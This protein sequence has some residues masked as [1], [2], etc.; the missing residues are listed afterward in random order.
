MQSSEVEIQVGTDRYMQIHTNNSDTYR[1]MQNKVYSVGMYLS[2]GY[3]QIITDTEMTL[4]QLYMMHC[5]L[6]LICSKRTLRVLS[7]HL[8]AKIYNKKK[9][10]DALIFLKMWQSLLKVPVTNLCGI[11]TKI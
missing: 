10:A 5:L 6:T 1:Y 4:N 11:L 2:V 8:Q 7:T 9:V 3:I